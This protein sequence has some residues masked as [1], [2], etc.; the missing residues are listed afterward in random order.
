MAALLVQ[1]LPEGAQWLYEGKFDGY[2]AY[3]IGAAA[4]SL[5]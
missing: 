2:R 5:S 3:A 4:P 1:K